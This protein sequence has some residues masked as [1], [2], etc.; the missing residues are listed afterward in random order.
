M[1]DVVKLVLAMREGSVVER[2]HTIKHIG[3]Y[4]NGQHQYDAAMLLLVL[5]PNPS[6]NLLLAV[7]THDQAERW[8]GD[9]PAPLKW[10]RP[11]IGQALHELEAKKLHELRR[12]EITQLTEDEKQWLSAVDR[13]ELWLWCQD[14]KAMGCQNL[15]NVV[16]ELE[17]SFTKKPL[18]KAVVQ[19]LDRY[20]WHR[21]EEIR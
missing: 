18:P 2:C 6:R 12:H 17:D 21:T 3:S 19:F 13:V 1:M 20:E 11:D 4:T 7:L 14:Q 9:M 16:K 5:H 15:C 10:L 8:Y